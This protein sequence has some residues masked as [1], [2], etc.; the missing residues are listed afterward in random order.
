[1]SKHQVQEIT[2][3]KNITAKAEALGNSS[4]VYELD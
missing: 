4:F 2:D 3:N 1:M